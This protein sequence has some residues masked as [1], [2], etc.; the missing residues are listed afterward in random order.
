MCEYIMCIRI[1]MNTIY[2]INLGTQLP[3]GPFINVPVTFK[4]NT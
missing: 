2:Q 4:Y 1:N 3:P